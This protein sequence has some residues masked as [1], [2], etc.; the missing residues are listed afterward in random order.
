MDSLS[1][2]CPAPKKGRAV[3]LSVPAYTGQML[4]PTARFV[5]TETLI[6]VSRGH[7]PHIDDECGNGEISNARDL[8]VARFLAATSDDDD[9]LAMIDADVHADSGSLA[10]LVDKP[11]DFRC[12]IYPQRRDPIAYSMRED[13]SSPDLMSSKTHGMLKIWGAPAGFM[14]LSR[15]MLR[16]M[17]EHYA[18]MNYFCDAAPNKVVCGLFQAHWTRNTIMP[19]GELGNIKL[20]EDYSFCQRWIDMGGE[21]WVEP[22]I[23]MGHVGLKAFS[24]CL[25]EHLVL[26]AATDAPAVAQPAPKP[27][28]V[29]DLFGERPG[30]K[31]DHLPQPMRAFA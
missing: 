29:A 21:V 26:R 1:T 20:S 5:T 30:I 2:D 17:T 16:R 6:L 14:V 15:R 10:D 12:G 23:R 9:A 31:S 7:I 24:G 3:W 27:A 18:D 4:V 13:Q 25:H 22:K 11:T 28:T 19:N 8:M